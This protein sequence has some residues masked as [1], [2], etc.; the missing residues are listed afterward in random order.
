MGIFFLQKL[1]EYCLLSLSKL[2]TKSPAASFC[3]FAINSKSTGRISIQLQQQWVRV[4]LEEGFNRTMF[5]FCANWGQCEAISYQNTRAKSGRVALNSAERRS[6]LKVQVGSGRLE[7]APDD[8]LSLHVAT[9]RRYNLSLQSWFR[10]RLQKATSTIGK[11]YFGKKLASRIVVA[12]ESA[13]HT[14]LRSGYTSVCRS[15]MRR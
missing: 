12:P 11:K 7:A 3:L 9:I 13:A 15:T 1:Q 4:I 6:W 14:D 2:H 5:R 8:V 10:T